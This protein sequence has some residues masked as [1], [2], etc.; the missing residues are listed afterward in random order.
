[1]N[2]RADVDL[3]TLLQDRERYPR[4]LAE[5]AIAERL[6]HVPM[7]ELHPTL[8]NSPLIYEPGARVAMTPLYREYIETAVAAGLPLLLTAPTWRLDAERVAAAGQPKRINSHAV[9]Y[10][11]GV[12]DR[13]AADAP[14][15]DLPVLV[16]ALVG[17]RNDCYQPERAPTADEAADFHRAQIDELAATE[18]DFL[19]AQTLPAVGE[20]IGIARRMAATGKPYLIS[21][22]AGTDGRVLD[23]SSLVEASAAVCGDAGVS[24]PPAGFMVN[25]THPRFLLAGG[26]GADLENGRQLV[27]IQA[28][29]SSK[30]VTALD[31]SD[32]TEAD[33]VAD[34]AADMF[35]L[36]RLGVRVL[37]GCCGTGLEHMQALSAFSG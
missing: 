28:N 6:R 1:M 21:F 17:P 2:A 31:G 7:V 27:G 29:G 34:W 26:V 3:P 32:A 20:A 24:R 36:H 13:F 16:G 23:G 25:C 37:G 35:A 18:A 9:R 4:I 8:F 19:L 33:P 11:R 30:D 15:P 10:M 12:R 22:C 14:N 5:C